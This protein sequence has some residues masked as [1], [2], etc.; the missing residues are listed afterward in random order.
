M[1]KLSDRLQCIA[2][3]IKRGETMADIGT[4]H[5]FLPL[6]LY[7]EG[8]SPK[9]IMADISEPSLSKA[10]AAAEERGLAKNVYCR[11][12]DG[13][14][15]LESGEVDAVVIAGMGGLL[16]CE[17]LGENPK[18]AHSF[19]KFILQPRSH[20]GQLRR[21][22]LNNGY[23]ITGEELVREGKFICEIIKAEPK[24]GRDG[25]DEIPL[26]HEND[27]N[28]HEAY[29]E[30]PWTLLETHEALAREFAGVKAQIEEQKLRGLLKGKNPD[31]AQ[32][33]RIKDRIGYFRKMSGIYT[34]RDIKAIIDQSV[35]ESTQEAWDNSGIQIGMEDKPV[36]RMLTCLEITEAVVSEAVEQK[37]D[38]IVSHHPLIFE[39]LSRI[40]TDS[41]KGRIIMKLIMNGISVYSSHTPFDKAAGGNNDHIC[42]LL[43]L[44]E[45]QPVKESGEP[46]DIC[47]WGKLK[48]DEAIEGSADVAMSFEKFIDYTAKALNLKENEIR[49]AGDRNKIIRK[50]AVCTG[51]GA[52]FLRAAMESGC[53]ALVTGDVKH[54]EGLDA[55]EEGFCLIDAGHYGTE[56][57][58]AHLMK[59]RLESLGLDSVEILES[60]IV[61]DPFAY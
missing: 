10:K 34:V 57:F 14:K 61:T 11:A 54:H 4:D 46:K 59:K 12:G 55:L 45:I 58:F 50:V 39:G 13:L 7:E 36:K 52:E 44:K 51:A 37:V 49:A 43:N 38:M 20:S 42:S 21:W 60:Q 48:G 30:L 17:I 26:L 27:R 32:C 16:M 25:A 40:D 6:Y 31:S 35:P 41:P 5:G 23:D 24:G 18:K 56:K 8:I 29:W 53:D 22:L 28:Y 33:R 19:K 2:D 1:I 47:L 3:N 15:V 9:V